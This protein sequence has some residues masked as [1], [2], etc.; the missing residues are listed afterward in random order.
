MAD[1]KGRPLW[2]SASTGCRQQVASRQHMTMQVQ[3]ALQAYLFPSQAPCQTQR[4]KG[5]LLTAE[6]QQLAVPRAS[7]EALHDHDSS[8][9]KKSS[10]ERFEHVLQRD[11]V[12][13][14]FSP[15]GDCGIASKHSSFANELK[16]NN[17]CCSAF[18]LNA[19]SGVDA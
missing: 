12:S 5:G 11:I 14:C 4:K 17:G 8:F 18:G 9:S 3:D 7:E 2:T 13:V 10:R 16:A 15:N 6:N 1:V 19:M